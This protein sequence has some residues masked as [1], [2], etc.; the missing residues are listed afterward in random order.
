MRAITLKGAKQTFLIS[1]SQK[2]FGTEASR[3]LERV[4]HHEISAHIASTTGVRTW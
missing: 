3:A 2:E 1:V 4:N